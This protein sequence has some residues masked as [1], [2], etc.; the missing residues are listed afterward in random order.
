[1]WM[2]IDDEAQASSFP[3]GVSLL[4]LTLPVRYPSWLGLSCQQVST[5]CQAAACALVRWFLSFS[6]LY[7]SS[8][9]FEFQNNVSFSWCRWTIKR[10]P[11]LFL[12][13]SFLVCRNNH[14]QC[15]Q[16]SGRREWRRLRWRVDRISN[17]W[18]GKKLSINLFVISSNLL[19]LVTPARGCSR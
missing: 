12:A 10:Q 2:M 6:S 11:A 1:M 16:W 7:H 3:R 5:V 18:V 19:F 13:G 14:L 17:A 15:S 8:F 9:S 4:H